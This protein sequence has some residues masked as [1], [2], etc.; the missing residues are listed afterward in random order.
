MS[1]AMTGL[2]ANAAVDVV[3]TVTVAIIGALAGSW[4][5]RGGPMPSGA[6]RWRGTGLPTRRR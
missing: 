5:V 2:S 1:I 6:N 4:L 3:W